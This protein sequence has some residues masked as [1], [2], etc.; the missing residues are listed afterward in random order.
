METLRQ[1]ADDWDACDGSMREA[2]G[3]ADGRRVLDGLLDVLG[4]VK[5]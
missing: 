3:G 5:S 2:S 4:N 1:S